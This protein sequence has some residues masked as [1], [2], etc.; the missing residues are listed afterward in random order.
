MSNGRTAAIHT[1]LSGMVNCTEPLKC[2]WRKDAPARD[3]AVFCSACG[4]GFDVAMLHM[5]G[6]IVDAADHAR[7]TERERCAK[8]ADGYALSAADSAQ[9]VFANA[10]EEA[11][12][13]KSE[14]KRA[15][16]RSGLIDKQNFLHGKRH[17]AVEIARGIREDVSP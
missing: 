4:S 12:A 16:I 10:A 5:A 1:V 6:R 8:I 2:S 9:V 15:E 3:C 13:T 7:A 11:R 14:T 17:C